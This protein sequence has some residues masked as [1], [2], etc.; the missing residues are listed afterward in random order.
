MK[1]KREG[2][3]RDGRAKQ[4][5]EKKEGKK[6]ESKRDEEKYLT[7]QPLGHPSKIGHFLLE[8]GPGKAAVEADAHFARGRE[9]ERELHRGE[10]G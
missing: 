4:N 3:E 7:R 10:D 1:Q 5:G 2:E 6:W 9:D 8:T